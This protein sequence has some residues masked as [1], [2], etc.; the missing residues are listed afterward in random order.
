MR[1]RRS[2]LHSLCSSSSTSLSLPDA[3][4]DLDLDFLPLGDSSLLLPFFLFSPAILSRFLISRVSGL[5]CM[6]LQ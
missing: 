3:D 1:A 5:A 2:T 6:K 4:G